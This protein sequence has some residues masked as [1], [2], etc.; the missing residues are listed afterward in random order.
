[1]ER[2]CIVGGAIVLGTAAYALAEA[3]GRSVS[4]SVTL[5][6]LIAIYGAWLGEKLFTKIHH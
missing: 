5:G 6:M 3:I 4:T 1:M 2:I